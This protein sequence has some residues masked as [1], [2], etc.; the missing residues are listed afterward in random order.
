M[1]RGLAYILTTVMLIIVVCQ[2][3]HLRAYRAEPV[4][5]IALHESRLI[6]FLHAIQHSDPNVF[7][8][9]LFNLS[10]IQPATRGEARYLFEETV[11]AKQ[12]LQRLPNVT[13][14]VP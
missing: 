11:V 6:P 3:Y 10:R 5:A 9:T 12:L 13:Q 8:S 1:N 7:E 2:G 4:K 14:Q